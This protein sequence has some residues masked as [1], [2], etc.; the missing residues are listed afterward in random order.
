MKQPLYVYG[1]LLVAII[2]ALIC[3]NQGTALD[4]A[5][6][7]I[8]IERSAPEAVT[9]SVANNT[10]N[11]QVSLACKVGAD[12]EGVSDYTLTVYATGKDKA[13]YGCSYVKT[14]ILASPAQ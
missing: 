12:V 13:S 8:K 10:T 3:V 4:E 11:Q 9:V 6:D 14:D 1:L 2:L 7:Q 5:L